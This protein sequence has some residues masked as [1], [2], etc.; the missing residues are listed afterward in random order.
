MNGWPDIYVSNDFFERDYIY[1]NNGDGTFTEDLPSQMKSISVA[2]MGA[3]MAD[4]NNDCYPDIFVT[5]MLPGTDK[6]L[7]TK[8]TFED[9]DKYMY[10]VDND[11]HHQFTRNML[12]LNQGGKGFVEVG[13]MAG[14]HATDWSWGAV[15]NDF[16]NDGWKDLFVSN[17]IYQDLT[18]QDFLNFISNEETMKSII[19]DNKVDYKKLI[20]A[21][22]SEQI[23]N[24]F[25][26]NRDGLHF[27]NR[28]QDFGLAKPSHSNGAAYG[29]LD[30][31]GDLDLVVNNVNMPCFV[32]RNN[33]VAGQDSTHY[34]QLQFKGKDKNIHAIGTKA[35]AYA[36]GKTYYSEFMPMKGFQSSM[37]YLMHIGI[38]RA[39]QIDSLVV[40][41]PDDKYTTLVKPQLDKLHFLDQARASKT[42]DYGRLRAQGGTTTYSEVANAL[43]YSH[44]ENRYVDFDRDRLMYHMISTEGPGA[45]VADFNGDGKQDIYIGGAKDQAG[46]LA[47]QQNGKFIPTTQAAFIA[48]KGCEDTDAIAFDVDG[49]GDMDLYVVSGGNEFSAEQA[50]IKDRLYLNDGKG[51]MTRDPN[52]SAPYTSDRTVAAGDM[53]GDGDIDLFVGERVKLFN[54]GVPCS[55]TLYRNDRGRLTDVTETVAPGLKNLGMITDAQW[56]DLNGDK[57]LDLVVV[58]EYMPI[59]IW[60]NEGTKMTQQT[61]AYG[62]DRSQG[63]HYSITIADV[64]KDQKP[65]LIVGN[66]GLNSRFKADD[67]HPVCLHINDFDQNGTVEQ[68]LCNYEEDQSY[69]IV[70][71]HDLVKQLPYLKKKYLQYSKY[72]NQTIENIFSEQERARML[73]LYAYDMETTV[74]LNT[75]K[76][77]VKNR[78]PSEVQ[79]S[80]TYS[81]CAL[82][83]NGDGHIDLVGGGN[84]YATKPEIGRYDASQGWVCYGD[85]RGGWTYVAERSS[86]IRVDG[87]VRQILPIMVDG[88][89]HLLFV[90][91]NASPV[92]YRQNILK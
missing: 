51:R 84:L 19:Q 67:T 59:S 56:A 49:D 6:R 17:G 41:Y 13:R 82:D 16:D 48:D 71:K 5:E 44:Q 18:D 79:Y 69:P 42:F 26:K 25:F 4:V 10:N 29:D 68:I 91:N 20:D 12:H 66:H 33:L 75:G 21:I 85:S 74:Y 83:V 35:I 37:Q 72:Q 90:R 86:G 23:P 38:G 22:P 27:D 88:R 65:D 87:E 81:V 58:G 28:A 11:Y 89:S 9:Y 46:V 47:L 73:T 40:I 70:L 24:Y 43:S 14:V 61:T 53:D 39:A 45:V 3:D 34:I 63:W 57:K 76:T 7:K 78:L 36:G 80:S 15:I 55:G 1:M 77:F 64:N 2:S 52:F 32:Y 50:E 8:T 30:G 31:D 54:Y 60:I 62:L 92:L